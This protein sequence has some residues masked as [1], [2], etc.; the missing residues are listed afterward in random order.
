MKKILWFLFLISFSA[1]NGKHNSQLEINLVPE[2]GDEIQ[3]LK[4]FYLQSRDL[5][6][7]KKSQAENRKIKSSILRIS[8]RK[9]LIDSSL[10]Q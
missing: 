2:K 9:I 4:T 6:E 10:L 5:S 7:Y 8:A 3:E 1:C